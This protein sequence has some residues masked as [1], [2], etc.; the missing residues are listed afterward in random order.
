MRRAIDYAI[1]RGNVDSTRL[2]Y[3]GVSWGGRMGAVAIAVE[4][5]F[6]A[7][8]ALPSAAEHGVGNAGVA[9]S[10][11][12]SGGALIREFYHSNHPHA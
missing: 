7:A 9:R 10:L 8:W 5:R 1:T 12:R 2:A 3:Q 4:P 6:K 11:P